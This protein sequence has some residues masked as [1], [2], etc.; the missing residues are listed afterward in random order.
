METGVIDGQRSVIL[1][2]GHIEEVA[3][4]KDE[5]LSHLTAGLIMM[6]LGEA[7]AVEARR[8][9]R[10]IESSFVDVPALFPRY[11]EH[12]YVHSVEMRAKTRFFTKRTV[13]I[14][15]R[16]GPKSLLEGDSTEEMP[17]ERVS[18]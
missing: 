1:S 3:G 14:A 18:W 4:G 7:A 15:R 6:L 9:H 5:L 12:K 10:E 11:M 2:F 17:E 8:I 13:G 16:G